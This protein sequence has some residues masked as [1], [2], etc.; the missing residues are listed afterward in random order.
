[1]KNVIR[2]NVPPD[3][4]PEEEADL[5]AAVAASYT[6]STGSDDVTVE[7]NRTEEVDY[8]STSAAQSSRWG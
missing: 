8:R 6:E 4:T 1:M 3:H 2:L 7:V 5:V